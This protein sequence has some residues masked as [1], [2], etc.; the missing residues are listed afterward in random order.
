[1]VAWANN[2]LGPGKAP[3][4]QFN[5]LAVS[6]DDGASFAQVA[7]PSFAPTDSENDAELAVD[8]GGLFYYVW[9]GYAQN[10]EGPQHVYASTSRDGRAWSPALQVD[11]PGDDGVDQK[12]QLDYPQLAINPVT[13]Q[14]YVT[15]EVLATSAPWSLKLVVGARGGASVAPS[16][17]LDDGTR[18]KSFRN[19]AEG[20]FDAKGSFYS[21]WIEAAGLTVGKS[22]DGIESGDPNNAI[23]FTRID[24]GANGAL[25]PLGRDIVVNA[26]GEAVLFDL[27]HVRVTPD[28]STVFVEYETGVKDAI[29]VRVV[30]SHDGGLT[31]GAPVKVNDD[32]TCATHFHANTALD[33]NHRLWVFWYDNRDGAGHFVYSV[34]DDG[35]QTFHKNRLVTPNAFPFEDFQYSEGWLG[36]Y[37]GITASG[38]QLFTAWSDSHDQDHSHIQFAHAAL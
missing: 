16:V 5:G 28:A 9:E 11:T 2:T 24:L 20:V 32:P 14:P 33:G 34:S 26:A 12:T 4:R 3:A 22:D 10:F 23:Y 27:T 31:W 37:L 1:L 18:P 17:E 25:A 13:R 6:N 21:V 8:G 36:D 30:T 29:D 19:S 15:Y 35:G 38:G 7:A